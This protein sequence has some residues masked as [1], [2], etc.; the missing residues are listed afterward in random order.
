M[1]LTK[2]QIKKIGFRYVGKDALISNKC[3]IY[4]A[5]NISIGDNVRIDDFC[6]LS[7]GEKIEIGNYV[8]IACYSVLL[9]SAFIELCDYSG[10]SLRCIV[11]SS[12]ADYSGEFMTNPQIPDKYLNTQSAPVVFSKHSLLGA[13]SIVLPGVSLGIGSVVGANSLVKDSVP[14]FEIWCGNP[15]KYKKMRKTD[16]LKLTKQLRHG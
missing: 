2:S 6:L 13:G 15:A 4:G 10:I 16:I 12:N 7:A 5:D 9:G 8:H 14:S 11:L 3:S 1:Y